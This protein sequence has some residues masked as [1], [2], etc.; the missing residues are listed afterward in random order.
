MDH[1]YDSEGMHSGR[2]K[3]VRLRVFTQSARLICQLMPS[4]LSI[5]SG[6]CKTCAQYLSNFIR[7]DHAS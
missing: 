4:L 2:M 3:A 6:D 5:F 7:Q 1:R